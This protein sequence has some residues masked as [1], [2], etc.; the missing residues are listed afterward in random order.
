[1]EQKIKVLIA[2]DDQLFVSA[3]KD[4]LTGFDRYEICGVADN[5]LSTL[6]LIE[7]SQPDV[8][9]LEMVMPNLDGIGVLEEL[10]ERELAKRPR[11]IFVTAFAQTN[12]T[13][14]GRAHV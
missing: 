12:L 8:V 3:A 2:D 6:E 1:M 10:H 9:V 7:S 11:I 13:K 5:G 4:F 14:I